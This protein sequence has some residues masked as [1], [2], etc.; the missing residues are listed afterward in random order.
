MQNLGENSGKTKTKTEIKPGQIWRDKRDH[1]RQIRVTKYEDSP[2]GNG[3]SM[4]VS[5]SPHNYAPRIK[6]NGRPVSELSFRFDYE[7]LTDAPTEAQKEQRGSE[8]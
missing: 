3:F 4:R 6:R 2:G 8:G 5:Y 7:L 1:A